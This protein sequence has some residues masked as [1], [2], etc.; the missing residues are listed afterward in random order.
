MPVARV[1]LLPAIALFSAACLPAWAVTPSPTPIPTAH[2]CTP[3]GADCPVG[4]QCYCCCGTWVCMPPY[5]PCCALPC[6]EP[7]ELPTPTPTPSCH[8]IPPPNLTFTWSVEPPYP[9]VGD[10]VQISIGVSGNG[11]L[12]RYQ[13]SGAQPVFQADTLTMYVD[14]PLGTVTFKM[15][16]AEVGTAS[17]TLSVDYETAYG[18][19]E[20]PYFNFTSRTSPPFALEVAPGSGSPTPTPTPFVVCT[21]P[22][23]RSDEVFYCPES[24]PGGCGTQCGTPTQSPTITPTPPG[25]CT[26]I[27][28]SGDCEVCPPCT[29]GTIC[30]EGPCYLGTCE[31]LE[32]SC[33]CVPRGVS[34]PTPTPVR[35]RVP[36]LCTGDCNADGQLTVNELVTG[37]GM[38]LGT[39]SPDT[40]PAFC[41]TECGPGPAPRLP[42]ITCL[43]RAINYAL[44]GCPTSC[45]TD[46]DCDA[47]NPCLSHRCTTNG[48]EYECLCF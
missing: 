15:R 20:N 22:P 23:C 30:P 19:Q 24:C 9:V 11:G 1:S 13:L 42:T 8:E 14:G 39:V 12:P 21:P 6:S 44:D 17:L 34:T 10:N 18:C 35:T 32:G 28:C 26:S 2:E 38:A 40:C 37:V 41:E 33:A 27:P 7:T 48:C 25:P 16:A 29:P 43:I 45:T 4:T 46:Q 31:M 3:S 36:P 47:G 5:L